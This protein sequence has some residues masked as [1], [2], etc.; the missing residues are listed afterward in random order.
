MPAGR[1]GGALCLL[2]RARQA[3]ESASIPRRGGL[4]GAGGPRTAEGAIP[5]PIPRPLGECHSCTIRRR[6]E[7]RCRDRTSRRHR[8]AAS[9]RL[10]PRAR[11]GRARGSFRFQGRR[12]WITGLAD[13]F[14]N[15][16]QVP[17]QPQRHERA[18]FS[19]IKF[20]ASRGRHDLAGS[21]RIRGLINRRAPM[22]S[23]PSKHCSSLPPS[24]GESSMDYFPKF[25]AQE[26][27]PVPQGMSF[28]SF[29]SKGRLHLGFAI[30]YSS[31]GQ[32][33]ISIAPGVSAFGN[34][35]G[36]IAADG[37]GVA[38]VVLFDDARIKLPFRPDAARTG[39]NPEDIA[40][41]V[42][43]IDGAL[44]VAALLQPAQ[45]GILHLAKGT[46]MTRREEV[47]PYFPSWSVET[48]DSDGRWITLC[49]FNFGDSGEK[50]AYW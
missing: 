9:S 13:N 26:R 48:K 11:R 30:G 15:P 33:F 32:E 41:A 2:W 34:R 19:V 31:G 7:R 40:G 44:G 24:E 36:F 10:A 23:T 47:D 22:D 46:P 27:G 43:L 35:P 21:A 8:L 16:P 14:L 49:A 42:V 20:G 17:Q 3:S 29:T 1:A 37:F 38:S 12:H 18:A 45:G 28:C 4:S 25:K 6:A 39:K 50:Q 5:N